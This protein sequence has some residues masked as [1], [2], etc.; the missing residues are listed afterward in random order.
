M[1]PELLTPT[2]FATVLVIYAMAIWWVEIRC[3]VTGISIMGLSH[4]SAAG[5]GA[6]LHF[7]IGNRKRFTSGGW[8]GGSTVTGAHCIPGPQFGLQHPSLS[9]HGCQMQ[10]VQ[11]IPLFLLSPEGTCIQLHTLTYTF[12]LSESHGI[13]LKS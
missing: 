12:S 11:G 7:R 8:R 3:S 5:F 9:F 1:A 4:L 2:G 10:G 6:D 13:H